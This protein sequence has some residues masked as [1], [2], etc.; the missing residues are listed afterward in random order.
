MALDAYGFAVAGTSQLLTKVVAFCDDAHRW[1]FG[2]A[3]HG[4]R[5]GQRF[6]DP[7]YVIGLR[8]TPAKKLNSQPR[9]PTHY[10]QK[11]VA[12]WSIV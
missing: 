10:Q 12:G 11:Y 2:T 6:A 8:A 5:I 1:S 4:D 9:L 3:G 7:C